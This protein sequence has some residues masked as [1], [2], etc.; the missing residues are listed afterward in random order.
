[1]KEKTYVNK[2]ADNCSDPETI[3][4]SQHVECQNKNVKSIGSITEQ[5][6]D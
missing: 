1:M 6:K 2:W 4:G 5:H 3:R